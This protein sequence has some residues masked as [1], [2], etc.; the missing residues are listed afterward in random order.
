MVN[1]DLQDNKFPIDMI[2]PMLYHIIKQESMTMNKTAFITM[3]SFDF[4]FTFTSDR[5]KGDL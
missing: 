5:C 4:F 2:H 1:F 3:A